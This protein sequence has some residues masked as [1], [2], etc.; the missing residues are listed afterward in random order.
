MEFNGFRLEMPRWPKMEFVFTRNPAT[1]DAPP[2]FKL[3]NDQ[4]V[5]E[6]DHILRI[7]A[8]A[9]SGVQNLAINALVPTG[10]STP[11]QYDPFTYNFIPASYDLQKL[12]ELLNYYVFGEPAPKPLRFKV[13]INMKAGKGKAGEIFQQK[14]QPILKA[15]GCDVRFGMPRDDACTRVVYTTGPNFAKTEV[16][17]MALG[18]YD[19][20]MCVGGD[21]LVH[22]VVNG[23]ASHKDGLIALKTMTIATIPAGMILSFSMLISRI[24]KRHDGELVWRLRPFLRCMASRQ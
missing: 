18:N 7:Y 12:V 5:I 13:F 17:G 4:L 21:G 15:A 10:K 1:E 20:I 3:N 23:L 19:A 6:F 14:V 2:R 24:W 22:E 9:K 11:P 8:G 16:S